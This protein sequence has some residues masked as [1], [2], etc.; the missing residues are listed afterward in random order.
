[1]AVWLTSLNSLAA[2]LLVF[3]I[4][5]PLP[6]FFAQTIY[7]VRGLTAWVVIGILWAFVSA[8]T[9]IMFPLYESREAMGMVLRGVVKVRSFPSSLCICFNHLYAPA[10]YFHE[11]FWTLYRPRNGN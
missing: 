9:V 10:G 7:G 6:L 11:R 1:M 4:I 5:V 2:Q 8:F 3:I